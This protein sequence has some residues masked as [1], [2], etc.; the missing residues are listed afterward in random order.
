MKC[1]PDV[2][3]QLAHYT[4]LAWSPGSTRG[5]MPTYLSLN[6]IPSDTRTEGKET[7]FWLDPQG[8]WSPSQNNYLQDIESVCVQL[9]AALATKL[10]GGFE[11]YRDVVSRYTDVLS[12]AGLNSECGLSK[13][14]FSKLLE[15]TTNIAEVYTAMYLFDCR[16]LVSGIQ[17]CSKEVVEL[18]GEFFRSLNMEELFVPPLREEDGTRWTTSP[19]VTKI[20]ALLGFIYIRL[21]SLLDY[22]TKLALE[23]GSL[24]SDFSRY[25]R[26]SST[27]RLYGD[28]G[29]VHFNHKKGT[30]F[31]SCPDLVEI[32][33][34]RNHI[35]HDGLLDDMP[36]VYKVISDGVCVEKYILFPDRSAE[37]R[38]ES[39]R[40][41]N[42]FYGREDK[43]NL[44]LPDL[45][46]KFQARQVE[47][48]KPLLE[49]LRIR[50]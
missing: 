13:D 34:V 1:R 46:S 14:D 50:N 26:L 37:G 24:K 40:N 49:D 9:H 11:R 5:S 3:D 45:I 12:T 20:F 4:T 18:Q 31:E 22:S 42:L 32:E 7:F 36:K 30:L 15:T 8:T 33:T 25:P 19:A 2:L 23:I 10:F 28:R 38:F 6:G 44:R 43:I 47:T 16:K 41:R 29:R 21:H 48:L 39:F 35:I 27:G 17:E